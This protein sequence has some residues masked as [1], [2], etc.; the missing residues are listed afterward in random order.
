MDQNYAAKLTSRT[1]AIFDRGPGIVLPDWP[2]GHD[3]AAYN[4]LTAAT[5]GGTLL[6]RRLIYTDLHHRGIEVCDVLTPEGILVH[7]KSVEAS[8]P[9]SHLLA[10]ALVSTDALLHDEEARARF[11]ERVEEKGGNLSHVPTPVH[12]VV[13][14]I[15]RKGKPITSNDLFTFTQVTLVRNVAPLQRRG[16]D[17]FVAP[18][19]RPE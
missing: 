18:I 2:P 3:E 15:A 19:E 17:L 10:Q 4:T 8:S 13:L 6:D 12:T 11:R 16:G 14:G 7:V 5:V 1:K 9:A